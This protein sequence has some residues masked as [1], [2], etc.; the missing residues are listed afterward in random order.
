[1]DPRFLE[2]MRKDLEITLARYGY[3]LTKE[4]SLRP[5]TL[6]P[7]L[8]RLADQGMLESQWEAS[9]HPGRPARHAYRLTNLGISLLREADGHR[10]PPVIDGGFAPA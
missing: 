1:M 2:Q 7:L 6:Y 4:T 5:G 3:D 9:P 8:M 10:N